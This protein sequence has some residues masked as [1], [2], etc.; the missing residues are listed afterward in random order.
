MNLG[1][2]RTA[3]AVSCGDAYTCAILDDDTLKCWGV[4]S[5]G[6]L[7]YGDFNVR[8]SVP[9][10]AAVN[11]GAGRTA[12]AVSCGREHT[13]AILDDD[14][15]KCWGRN[16]FLGYGST[17]GD[18]YAPKTT[19]VNLG[20][21][22]TA[23]SVS[24]QYGHTCAILDDDTVKCWGTGSY[25]QLGYGGTTNYDSPPSSTGNLGMGATSISAGHYT[26]CAILTNGGVK[27]WGVN[28]KGQVGDGTTT[29]RNSPVD[30]DL[31][32][33][34]TA[35][36]VSVG[37]SSACAVLNDDSVKCLGS[38]GAAEF[39]TGNQLPSADNLPTSTALPAGLTA[40]SVSTCETESI[41][42]GTVC[43]VMN[44]DSIWCWGYNGQGLAGVGDEDTY[45]LV[46]TRVCFTADDCAAP[47]GP[48]GPPG[49]DGSPGAA[50]APGLPLR[51]RAAT[52]RFTCTRTS[53][54]RGRRV[55]PVLQAPNW[56]RTSTQRV[57][58][59]TPRFGGSRRSRCWRCPPC[60][61]CSS[62][63]RMVPSYNTSSSR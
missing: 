22:R 28:G 60:S 48:P 42:Y 50:G 6:E 36:M 17:S 40:K 34:F 33:G 5:N 25:G 26:S 14:T 58:R 30:I 38:N 52:T 23:K 24:L 31:G 9:E 2:G 3:K 27:C 15:L 7:G 51:A 11:L 43:A 53:T 29:Q 16:Y 45:I 56:T 44:D 12:K 19:A 59:W 8:R 47:S 46:P 61:T 57:T 1:S 55:Q 49:N 63:D 62:T 13:C 54:C 32:T 35:K 10:A 18:T 41:S 20:S 21:G 37:Y 4:N 39:G